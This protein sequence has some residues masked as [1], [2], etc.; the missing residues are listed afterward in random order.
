MEKGQKE[1]HSTGSQVCDGNRRPEEGAED[2]REDGKEQNPGARHRQ[3]RPWVLGFQSIEHKSQGDVAAVSLSLNRC[4]SA[5][6]I[7]DNKEV[8]SLS[9]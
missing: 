3:T 7:D 2:E 1:S 5:M 8:W 6:G 4:P 9:I